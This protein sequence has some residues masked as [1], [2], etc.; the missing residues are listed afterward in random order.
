MRPHRTLRLI[1]LTTINP[2]LYNH[3]ILAEHQLIRTRRTRFTR[4]HHHF[5]S[6]S[7]RDEVNIYN[8]DGIVEPASNAQKLAQNH[9][10]PLKVL[11]DYY[12]K[13]QQ[14]SCRMDDDW[15]RPFD[16]FNSMAHE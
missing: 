7:S 10:K 13:H 2:S 1:S 14:Y 9:G 11:L 5:S 8:E 4:N 3:P 12:N 16:Q 15:S 6:S